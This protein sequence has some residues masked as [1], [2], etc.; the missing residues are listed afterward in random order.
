M[1]PPRPGTERPREK[2]VRRLQ[3]NFKPDLEIRDYIKAEAKTQGWTDSLVL[4][5]MLRTQKEMEEAFGDLWW[6]VAAEA[7][8]RQTGKGKIIAELALEA[9]KKRGRGR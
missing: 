4:N 6:E 7:V 5:D 3:M 9:L 8:R 2:G 1:R